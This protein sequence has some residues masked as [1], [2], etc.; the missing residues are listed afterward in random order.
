MTVMATDK[1]MK[2][3]W[4]KEDE[5]GRS[6]TCTRCGMRADRFGIGPDSYT[7]FTKA[8]QPS[9]EGGKTPECV[10]AQDE[11]YPLRC[12]RCAHCG[13]SLH[14]DSPTDPWRDFSNNPECEIAPNPD[15]GPMPGHEPGTPVVRRPAGM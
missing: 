3:Q 2:H 8:G 9:Q 13:R 14:K 12:M 7:V 4:R 1:P 15:D 6:K 11:G 5:V 10:P